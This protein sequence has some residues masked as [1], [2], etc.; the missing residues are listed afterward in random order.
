MTDDEIRANAL[1]E[2]KAAGCTCDVEIDVIHP[3]PWV[4]VISFGHDEDCQRAVEDDEAEDLDDKRRR[5][6]RWN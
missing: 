5:S 6:A 2:I 1:E 3:A 4:T